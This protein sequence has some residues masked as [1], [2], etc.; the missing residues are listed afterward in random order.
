LPNLFREARFW[1][2]SLDD[3]LHVSV[4]S[5]ELQI[6]ENGMNAQRA[7]AV[8]FARSQGAVASS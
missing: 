8:K 2:T 7:F 6:T 1:N 4:Q 5:E 3:F